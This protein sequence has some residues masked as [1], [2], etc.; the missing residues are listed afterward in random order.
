MKVPYGEGL[1]SHTV[2]ESCVWACKGAGEALIGEVRA[3][4]LS[5]E[6]YGFSFRVLTPCTRAE[7]NTDYIA[8]ARCDRTLRGL[9]PRARTEAPHTGT[10]RS[11]VWPQGMVLR[12]VL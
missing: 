4:L 6:R 3:G 7:G 10:G 12:S 2:P 8:R 1:A 5:R 11:H 9:R